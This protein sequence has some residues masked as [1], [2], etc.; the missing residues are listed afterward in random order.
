MEDQFEAGG[1]TIE[2]MRNHPPVLSS[3]SLPSCYFHSVSALC[4]RLSEKLC[5][6]APKGECPVG[7]RTQ[8]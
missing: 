1:K 6:H 7:C 3:M 8:G 4:G 2:N 5:E